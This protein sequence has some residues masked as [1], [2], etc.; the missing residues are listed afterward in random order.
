MAFRPQAALYVA[1]A[2]GV[3]SVFTTRDGAAHPELTAATWDDVGPIIATS[4]AGCHKP[5]GSALPSLVTYEEARAIAPA[6]KRSVLER[7]MPPWRA[8]PGFGDF[9]NDPTLTAAQMELVASWAD[10]G[11][12]RGEGS[13]TATHDA[14]IV[15]EPDVVLR[16]KQEHRIA[17]PQQRF[18]LPLGES[19]GRWLRGWHFRPGNAAAVTQ[20]EI[21][22][23]S[24]GPLGTWV[25]P[26]GPVLLPADTAYPLPR[27]V[28]F[29]VNVRYRRMNPTAVDRSELALYF[30]KRPRREARHLSVPCGST[31]A[32]E[33]LE[34]LSVQPALGAFGD[35]IEIV[36]TRPDGGVTAL[37]WFRNY[38]PGYRATYRFRAPVSLP[39]A[40][41]IDVRSKDRT[42]TA[43]LEYVASPN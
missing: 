39:R 8:A 3:L 17:G 31:E 22:M 16:P 23:A 29:L 43:D 36:A 7:R 41:R 27:N 14:A 38:P 15:P 12:R 21:S 35:A 28:T 19:E 34:V 10:G 2:L 13:E 24:S 40:T 9:A 20:A 4:C 37:G 30:S 25:P 32:R 42:C 5:A 18:E 6:I 33:H 11:A 1:A 26:E